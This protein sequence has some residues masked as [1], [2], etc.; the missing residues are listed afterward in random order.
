MVPLG[1]LELVSTL[2]CGTSLRVRRLQAVGPGSGL[3]ETEVGVSALPVAYGL[4]AD[5][6]PF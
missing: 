5:A 3:G 1:R 2:P 6:L 4:T